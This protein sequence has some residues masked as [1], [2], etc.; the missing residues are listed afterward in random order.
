MD[1]LDKH[2]TQGYHLLM[3]NV[4]ICTPA[5]V[6]DSSKVDIINAY[7][8][9]HSPFLN[10]VEEFWS[11]V[12]AGVRRNTLTADDRLSDHMWKSVQK[13]T[14]ANCQ[15]CIR[16]AVSFITRCELQETDL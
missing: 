3:E 11:K 14:H 15:A 13:L 5:K 7:T 6:R 4:Q 12:K 8:F 16:H 9:H 10:A 1:V 2:N